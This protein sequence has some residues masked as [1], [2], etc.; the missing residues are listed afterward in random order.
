MK[1][2][3]MITM[4]LA[5]KPKQ[6]LDG[7][8]KCFT[9]SLSGR[10]RQEAVNCC[11]KI[12]GYSGEKCVDKLGSPVFMVIQKEEASLSNSL[13]SSVPP[14]LKV[15]AGLRKCPLARPGDWVAASRQMVESTSQRAP[16]DFM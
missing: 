15:V 3:S 8:L 10:E 16:G 13:V 11:S 5:T 9:E 12:K 1:S 7:V 4:R 6:A 2:M 14:P